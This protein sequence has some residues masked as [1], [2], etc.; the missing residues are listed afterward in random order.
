[1][2]LA[3]GGKTHRLNVLI[4]QDGL[5]ARQR[6]GLVCMNVLDKGM[7]MRA[8]QDLA[9]QHAWHSQIVGVNRFTQCHFHGIETRNTLAYHSHLF[10]RKIFRM[11]AHLQH[12]V[13][14]VVR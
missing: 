12:L 10:R 13:R 2:R 4:C 11:D 8:V 3:R 1:M 7:S 14:I 5:D 9:E 6:A